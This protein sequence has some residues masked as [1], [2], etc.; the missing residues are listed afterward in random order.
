MKSRAILIIAACCLGAIPAQAQSSFPYGFTLGN[1]VDSHF[2]SWASG[3]GRTTGIGSE[4]GGLLLYSDVKETTKSSWDGGI[5]LFGNPLTF[6]PTSGPTWTDG[7]TFDVWNS[8]N[9]Y[10][11]GSTPVFRI[12]TATDK[13]T[14][15]TL[16]VNVTNG[17]LKVGGSAVLTV[18]SA[19]STLVGQGFL[20]LS[21]GVV[22]IYS[23]TVSSSSST[24]AFTVAGGIGVAK[25]S[26]INGLRVGR[27]NNDLANN[28]AIGAN[29]LGSSTGD[30]NTA[31]GSSALAANS[32]GV[33][34]SAF[35]AN[36]LQSNMT[37]GWNAAFGTYSLNAN[38]GSNNTAVG[39]KSLYWKSGGSNN[40]ALGYGAGEQQSGG[41]NLTAS[42]NS[43]YIGA[44]SKGKDNSDSN[45]IVI[46]YQA[47]G[48][49]ANTTVIG[50]TSTVK[51]QL[52]G[53]TNASSLKVAGETV[54]DGQ[55]I[56][57][58]P[59]GDISMGIYQ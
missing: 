22:G 25:D 29:V 17:S 32:S 21:G 11:T 33:Q 3:S 7:G 57:S 37:G 44:Y 50:N 19:A 43:V 40:T 38:T 49:G 13:A 39:S 55:V 9:Y 36:T 10:T 20:Q 31:T 30:Y 27:G 1:P 18:S 24:G 26:W 54:L 28:T 4:T 35:G 46:G 15:D 34:N 58:Q 6:V 56:I 59:Q 16:E 41:S 12:N 51:T 8:E 52:Y 42:S 5:G 53:E 47:V 48:L 45:S 23:T 14:F 2:G